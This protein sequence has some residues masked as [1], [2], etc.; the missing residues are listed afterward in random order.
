MTLCWILVIFTTICIIG[1]LYFWIQRNSD[2]CIVIRRIQTTDGVIEIVNDMCKEGLPHTTGPNTI[3]MTERAYATEAKHNTLTHERIHL[4]QKRRPEAWSEFYK[5]HW[6]YRLHLTPPATIPA[7]LVAR[8]R[9]NPDTDAA[10]WAVWRDRY[11]FFPVYADMCTPSL[12]QAEVIVWDTKLRRRV[13]I[14]S[15]WRDEFCISNTCPNQYE[16]PHELA[17][18]Y[19]A[20]KSDTPAAH[21]LFTW[22]H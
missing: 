21:K 15:E 6:N 19:I 11:V 2:D 1:L 18:E 7:E 8:R 4:D 13:A 17:A 12:K 9:P 14:P 16:H 22:Y 3:R 5:R 20:L 10:P